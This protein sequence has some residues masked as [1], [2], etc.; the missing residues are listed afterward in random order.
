MSDSAEVAQNGEALLLTTVSGTAGTR[1]AALRP[2]K[3]L[4][5]GTQLRQQGWAVRAAPKKSAAE[6]A[7]QPGLS[8]E[9]QD[10]LCEELA[11][12]LR[13]DLE[14]LFDDQGIDASRYDDKV[15]FVDP[16]TKY[17]SIQGYLFNISMLRRVFSPTFT[18]HDIRRT[19]PLELTTRWT[20]TMCLSFARSGPLQR[21]FDPRLTF[22]GTSIMGINP[23]TGR[24]NRHVDTWD[25]V[26]QQDY[27]SVEAFIHMLSQVLDL[28]KGPEVISSSSDAAA[29]GHEVLLKRRRYEVR[30]YRALPA[31]AATLPGG[32][33]GAREA[34]AYAAAE[35]GGEATAAAAATAER[36]L[37]QALLEDG[38]QPAAGGWLVAGPESAAP[39]LRRNEVL[40]PLASFV[41]W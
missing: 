23:K 31:A 32:S 20:M 12:F 41:L 21:V 5:A 28:R 16:I 3:A 40:I 24:F 22:T 11:A 30:K 39:L 17:S 2:M 33:A 18:L 29:G 4:R 10:R 34:A 25:A 1:A 26:Q 38:L 13:Q 35:F 15:D 27:F 37:R 14:H 7:P 19:G 8:T 6:A 9:E 36:A